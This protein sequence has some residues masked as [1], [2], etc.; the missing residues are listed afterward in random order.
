M[1]L[2]DIQNLDE[3]EVLRAAIDAT[4]AEAD[5]WFVR[6][7]ALGELQRRAGYKDAAVVRYARDLGIG[8]TLAFEL[9]A[10]DRRILL[11]RLLEHGDA[12][13]FPIRERRF[14]SVA[15]RCAPLVKRSALAILAIAEAARAKDRRFTARKLQEQLGVHATRDAAHG[16][17]QCLAKISALDEPTRKRVARTAKH[18]ADVVRL[19]EATAKNARLLADELRAQDGGEG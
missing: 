16:I 14:Y 2:Q 1:N 17:T 19:A 12:A 6:A 4:G 10:I 8:K 13:R 7:R 9:C 11:P 18:P 5:G 3:A 15:V